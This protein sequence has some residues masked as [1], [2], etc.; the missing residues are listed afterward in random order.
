MSLIAYRIAIKTTPSTMTSTMKSIITV[1]KAEQKRRSKR[2]Q[3]AHDSIK[4]AK[5]KEN[6]SRSMIVLLQHVLEAFSLARQL[7]TQ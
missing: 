7:Y 4:S 2:V 5:K 6:C 3:A 1:E